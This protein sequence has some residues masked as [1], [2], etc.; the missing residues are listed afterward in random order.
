MGEI[1]QA[2]HSNGLF[3]IVRQWSFEI[4]PFGCARVK[5]AE[6]PR[7]EHLARE[8]FREPRRVDFIAQHRMTEVMQMHADLM[9]ATAVESA[10][11][12]TCLLVRVKNA[13]FG[14]GRATAT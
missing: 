14:P 9:C 2:C 1:S 13:V 8:T 4:L 6:L 10:F 3:E 7:M 5:E 11:K 12:E